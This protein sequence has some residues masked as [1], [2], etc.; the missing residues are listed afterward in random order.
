VDRF[1]LWISGTLAPVVIV[2]IIALTGTTALANSESKALIAQAAFDIYSLDRE[3][4]I[5]TYRKAVAADPD[6]AAAYRGLASA[7]WLSIT[8][9]RGNMTVD[10]YLGK[11][12]RSDLKLPPP[13]GDVAAAFRDAVDQALALG[14]KHIAAKPKDAEAHFQLGSA[15]GLRASYVVTVDG[16]ILGGVRAARGAY[17]EHQKVLELDPRRADAGLIVGTYRYLVSALALPMR[18][19]AYMA[20][21]GG[22]KERG[23]QLIRG[24]S[25]YPGENQTDARLA[26]LLIYNRE[27]RFD[28]ALAELAALRERYPRNRIF[29]LETG[30]TYL[31]AGRPAEA[32]RFL[33]DGIARLSTDD[34]PRMFGEP[35]LWYYKRGASRIALD[36]AAEASADLKTALASE[37]RPWVYGRTHLEMGKLA[38]KTGDRAGAGAEFRQAIALCDG[39]NDAIA[40][41]EARRLLQ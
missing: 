19:A 31:R 20:G 32:E 15:I 25:E 37:G 29:W 38:L 26:L 12:T 10:D 6:D 5:D 40:A 7:L 14:R 35:A 33:N 1:E 11:L 28:D 2:A 23:I 41:D 27:G 18:W 30:A 22:G 21:F 36:R 13:P 16:S 4:A 3:H 34:R 24:A 9:H 39:D 8:F 17:E